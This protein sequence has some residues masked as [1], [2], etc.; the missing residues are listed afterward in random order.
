[1]YTLG[2]NA[3]FHDSS[4]CLVEDGQVIAAVEEERFTRIKHGKRPVPFSAWELPYHAIDYCLAEAGI[5]L[6][7]VDAVAYSYDPFMLLGAHPGESTLSLPLEPSATP[8][9]GDWLSPWEP[10]L[11]AYVVNAERQLIDGAPLHVRARFKSA[12]RSRHWKWQFV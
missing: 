1:M 12:K 10:L 9:K 5:E 6:A 3:A 11:A 7:D 4:A 2:I 8:V